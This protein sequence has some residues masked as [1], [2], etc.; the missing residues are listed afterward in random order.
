MSFKFSDN[1]SYQMIS[2]H[3]NVHGYPR[4]DKRN[5]YSLDEHPKYWENFSRF[6]TPSKHQLETQ[7]CLDTLN[8]LNISYC[9][10]NVI[11][12]HNLDASES[13]DI[14]VNYLD[15][16]FD[17]TINN[18]KHY[19][20]FTD[21]EVI[22]KKYS[23]SDTLSIQSA[24]T[25]K[26]IF[27]YY[28]YTNKDVDNYG[29]NSSIDAKEVTA[30]WN[31]IE[32]GAQFDISEQ[33]LP[34]M[35]FALGDTQNYKFNS[36]RRTEI[37]L[38]NIKGHKLKW[39]DNNFFRG[40]VLMGLM[41]FKHP[42]SAQN[43]AS[44]YVTG[45]NLR[46]DDFDILTFEE[47]KSLVDIIN[48]H[49]NLVETD[50]RNVFNK[51]TKKLKPDELELL[52]TTYT[53]IVL[54][55]QFFTKTNYKAFINT[56]GKYIVSEYISATDK[57]KARMMSYP[58]FAFRNI[59]VQDWD[60]R[61]SFKI[62]NDIIDEKITEQKSSKMKYLKQKKGTYIDTHSDA[63]YN[64]IENIPSFYDS[65]TR[66]RALNKRKSHKIK[67]KLKKDMHNSM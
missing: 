28:Y 60:Q 10:S 49:E 39:D 41:H 50:I 1:E 64:H 33:N 16:T 29:F 6:C 25:V 12:C 55:K 63:K 45:T 51:I 36:L 19:S 46:F 15:M 57:E 67:T 59:Y 52:E 7:L 32:K 54:D 40:M 5:R 53:P 22:T 61:S 24:F 34:L 66:E 42:S 2:Q 20:G 43:L 48:D 14:N 37:L 47:P 30:M 44:I 23:Y 9:T 13:F 65:R 3:K 18:Y 62:L 58:L 31:I 35:P 4:M 38:W 21:K 26:D 27:Q 8:N 17:V 11:T 56:N